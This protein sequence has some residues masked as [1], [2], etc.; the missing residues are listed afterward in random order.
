MARSGRGAK[1][2]L[3]LIAVLLSYS[4]H[5]QGPSSWKCRM[6]GGAANSGCGL[7]YSLSNFQGED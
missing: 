2:A 7:P 1:A 5:A 3:I 6:A 4:A